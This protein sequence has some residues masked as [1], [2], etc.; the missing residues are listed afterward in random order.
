MRCEAFLEK[1]AIDRLRGSRALTGGDDHLAIGGRDATGGVETRNTRPHA[2]I[3]FD[4][5]V[6]IERRAKF[7]R[8]LVV[9][10]VA[11]GREN[12]VDLDGG[13]VRKLKRANF[14]P[15]MIDVANAFQSDR[16]L[17]FR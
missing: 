2:L 5:P 12:V 3:D 10:N 7:L 16:N 9:E 4:L 11:A 17:V 15:S 1:I 13:I 6:G 14:S 8:E